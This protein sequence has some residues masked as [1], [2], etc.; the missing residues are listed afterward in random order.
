[1]VDKYKST[2]RINH[3][4]GLA[5]KGKIRATTDRLI[6]CKFKLDRR[7]SGSMVKVEIENK[8]GI[9]FVC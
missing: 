2:E 4:F 8:R 6:Q 9:S 5:R 3:L 1:M 7:K